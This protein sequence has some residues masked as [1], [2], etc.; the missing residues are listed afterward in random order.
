MM[1]IY[2]LPIL[3][4]L[5]LILILL[6]MPGKDSFQLG[7]TAMIEKIGS[8]KFIIMADQLD[9]LSGRGKP[10][11]V[12]LSRRQEYD[13]TNFPGSVNLPLEELSIQS[14]PEHFSASDTFILYSSDL[15]RSCNTWILLTQ[16]GYENILVLRPD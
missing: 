14:I 5:L 15:S 1:K 10:V 8:H 13:K 9:A 6:A 11:L 16:M 3:S 12:D 2:F 7:S 4:A